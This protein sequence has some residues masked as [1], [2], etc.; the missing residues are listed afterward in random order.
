MHVI[1]LVFFV[2]LVE[3]LRQLTKRLDLCYWLAKIFI[4]FYFFTCDFSKTAERIL[5]K[6]TTHG[7][8]ESCGTPVSFSAVTVTLVVGSSDL[9]KPR[10]WYGL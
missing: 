2:P 1:V 7:R 6:L 8:I 9:I 4:F 3:S 5:T 10:L